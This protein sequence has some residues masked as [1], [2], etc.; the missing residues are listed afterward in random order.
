MTLKFTGFVILT[1]SFWHFNSLKNC[2]NIMGYHTF[3][4]I[5]GNYRIISS[6]IA[7]DLELINTIE[8][9]GW[10]LLFTGLN[11]TNTCYYFKRNNEYRLTALERG[12]IDDIISTLEFLAKDKMICFDDEIELLKKIRTW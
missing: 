3:D 5:N 11:G 2:I 9:E 12:F 4:E 1:H 6:S 7:G 8:A 10:K